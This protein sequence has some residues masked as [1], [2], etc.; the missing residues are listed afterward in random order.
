M[1]NTPDHVK[2]L[3]T[4]KEMAK[5]G[6]VGAVTVGKVKIEVRPKDRIEGEFKPEV[7]DW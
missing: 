3:E 7:V 1:S 2:A 4:A 5:A 6:L